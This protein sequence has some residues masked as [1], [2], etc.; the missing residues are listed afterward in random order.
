MVFTQ[1]PFGHT[2]HVWR[3]GL[4]LVES[5]VV[6][7]SL[8]SFWGGVV[9]TF[10]CAS[11]IMPIVDRKARDIVAAEVRRFLNGETT[12]FAFDDAIYDVESDDPTIR[13]IVYRL[14]HHYDDCKDHTVTLSKPEW[15]YFQRLLLILESDRH[16]ESE[17]TRTWRWS[18]LFA[19]VGLLTFAVLV[20]QLGF[21]QHLL[22]VSIP[23]GL[24]SMLIAYFRERTQQPDDSFVAL[25]PFAT[26]A[27]LRDTY[28]DVDGFQ[29]QRFRRELT[30]SRIRSD[31]TNRIM[32]IPTWVAWLMF[33]PLVLLAQSLP[34]RNSNTSVVLGG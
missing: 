13:D 15:N 28:R 11:L 25:T 17:T 1:R 21:G 5:L 29:K 18:Q 33:A 7:T 30:D 3:R 16:I 19:I 22:V 24:I 6:Q 2:F 32:M 9:K 23:F 12:A 31:A 10:R 20:F 8:A 34:E 26:F 14:W 27:E 4:A